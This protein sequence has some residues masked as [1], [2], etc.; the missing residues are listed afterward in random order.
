[1][2]TS[3][4]EIA[5]LLETYLVWSIL[6]NSVIPAKKSSPESGSSPA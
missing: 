5:E 2:K 6:Q 4:P 3:D 1:M